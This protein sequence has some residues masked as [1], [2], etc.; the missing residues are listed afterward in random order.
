MFSISDTSTLNL[1]R[2]W[3]PRELG[4]RTQSIEH[5]RR[6]KIIFKR[7]TRLS[8]ISFENVVETCSQIVYWLTG[9]WR[10]V[11]RANIPWIVSEWSTAQPHNTGP[12]TAP[13]AQDCLHCVD[14]VRWDAFI[15][16][17]RKA[18]INPSQ[19]GTTR[20]CARKACSLQ[21]FRI[22]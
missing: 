20:A 16:T 8:S 1:T 18:A 21:L 11:G 2:K 12:C 6:I 7:S 4:E 3:K 19:T 15:Q 10:E 13:P 5:Y 14:A 9:L 22:C 17:A